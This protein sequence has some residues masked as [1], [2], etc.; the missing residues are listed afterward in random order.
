MKRLAFSAKWLKFLTWPGLACA[1]AGLVA[2][3]LSG[4]QLLPTALMIFGI[5]LLLLGLSFTGQTAGAFWQQ[6]STQSGTNAVV[7]TIAVLVILGLVNFL[8]VQNAVRY[9]LTETQLFTL[10]P[11]TQQVV[12]TLEAPVRVVIFDSVQNPQDVQLLESYREESDNFD[13]EYVDPFANP[14]LAEAFGATQAGMVFLEVGDDRRFLQTIGTTVDAQALG[15]AQPLSE[16]DLTNAL[17][18]LNSDRTLTVYFMQ[19]HD[20]PPIDG[21]EPGFAEAVQSLTDQ[22]Y[23]VEPLNL[24]ETQ[25][26]PSDANVVVVAGP[27]Q[28]FFPAE[29]AALEAYLTRGGGV[30]LLLDPRADAGL[31]P[32]LD[33]WGVIL[34]D[35]LVLDTSGAG[36]FVGL[37]PAAPIVTT[38]GDHPITQDF[39]DGRSFYPLARPVESRELP[40]TDTAP[41]LLTNPQSRAEAITDEGDLTFDPNAPP[42]GPYVLGVALSREADPDAPLPAID[43]AN[44][45]TDEIG[46]DDDVETDIEEESVDA[47]DEDEITDE[48]APTESET[49]DATEATENLP[50]ES[51]LVV[52]GNSTFALDGSFNQQLNGDVFLNSVNWL[53]QEADATLSIRPRTMTDRRL[54]IT[55]QQA[56]GLGIFSLVVLPLTG[57]ALAILMALRRR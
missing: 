32:L 24:V 8:A 18:Q 22:N 40:D 45:A 7:A 36:Q 2:G 42:E 21:S 53:S 27:V 47:T 16:Q 23:Q 41:L 35:R 48:T 33:D 1:T 26:V 14:R 6:R 4:W 29:V 39:G 28:D 52:I 13:F 46:D 50:D 10:A 38:Y 54:A 43:D 37:G 44:D 3:S 51:R 15:T 20:E 30:L 34:D 55:G 25:T 9:D 12:Q 56:W 17:A 19:G 11:A 31:N 49:I 57:I 5:G